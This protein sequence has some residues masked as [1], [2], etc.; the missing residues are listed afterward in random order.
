MGC[1][2]NDSNFA[3]EEETFTE[4]KEK[5]QK[6]KMYKVLL[7][8]DDYTPMMF[9]V[10]IL[11]SIFHKRVT[12]AT[13]IMWTVHKKGVGVAG[14]YTREISETKL[15]QIKNAAENEQHPLKCSMERVE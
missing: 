11:Q 13:H 14:I 6:P 7:H 3:L 10:F 1:E 8:N 9:V 5:L 12:E 15:N 2:E 4:R